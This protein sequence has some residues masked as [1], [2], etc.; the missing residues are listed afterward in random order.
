MSWTTPLTATTGTLTSAQ[1]NASVRDNLNETA[2]AKAT[3]PGSIFVA[4]GVN[5]IAERIID[6]SIVETSETS[7]S[8][9][10]TNLATNGP[11]VTATT[12]TQA[13]SW[14]NCSMSNSTAGIGVYASLEISGA[15]TLTAI[16][17]RGLYLQSGAT[18]DT[19]CGVCTLNGVTP[20][21][22]TFRMQYRVTANT[23]TWLRRRLIV[24][25]L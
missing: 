15:T 21:V 8:T 6:D 19:R 7:T 23:G 9:T 12:G 11:V 1:W 24:M 22:N 4:T 5:S 20:G 13:L 10:Y 17:Q 25:P 16:D 3:T 2:P 14:I 18:Y